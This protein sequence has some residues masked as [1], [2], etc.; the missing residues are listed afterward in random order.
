V[1]WA[2]FRFL[3]LVVVT[4][5]LLVIF[6]LSDSNIWIFLFLAAVAV[7]FWFLPRFIDLQRISG[8]LQVSE[9]TMDTDELRLELGEDDWTEGHEKFEENSR[10]R[11]LVYLLMVIT[12]TLLILLLTRTVSGYQDGPP[13]G[14]TGG[15]GESSCHE[16]HFDHALND[17]QGALTILG[18]PESY[19]A[20]NPYRVRILLKRPDLS[21]GGF[22][23]SAR[24]AGGPQRG[25]QAGSLQ[26]VDGGV[27]VMEGNDKVL[28]AH[29]SEL[30]G[31]SFSGNE[32]T[33]TLQWTA[34]SSSGTVALHVAANAS[35]NDDSSLGDF[36]YL[37]EVVSTLE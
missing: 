25:H 7:F 6:S 26:P 5:A 15:F 29:H 36:I 30:I 2:Y 27:K 8:E 21:R 37:K 28:Y 1:P 17:P 11:Q 18:F 22:Q 35:N 31:D 12:V 23:L 19:E 9:G 10:F 33:W 24:F 3:L 14:S 4:L 32:I 20:N 34:P 13:P 16:C